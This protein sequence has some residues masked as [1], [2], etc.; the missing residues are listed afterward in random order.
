[1]GRGREVTEAR[2]EMPARSQTGQASR[3]V[4][5]RAGEVAR[6]SAVAPDASRRAVCPSR[7][8]RRRAAPGCGL[9]AAPGS[10]DD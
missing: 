7:L 8:S 5:R 10:S 9:G 4:S 3:P 6:Q 1:M 2:L